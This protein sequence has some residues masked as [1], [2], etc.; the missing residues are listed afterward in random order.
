MEFYRTI[1]F[2]TNMIFLISLLFG[3]V[4]VIC[5]M[6]QKEVP[7]KKFK[8]KQKLRSLTQTLCTATFIQMGLSV[9]SYTVLSFIIQ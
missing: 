2:I 9:S 1:I 4:T 3:F 7:P 5:H 6:L 8:K